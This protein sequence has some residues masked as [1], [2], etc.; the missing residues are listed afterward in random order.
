MSGPVD[1]DLL[2]Y[3]LCVKLGFCLPPE[4]TMKLVENPPEEV[5]AF[6]DAVIRAEGLDP[7]ILDSRVRRQVSEL[8][9]GHFRA[10]A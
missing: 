6:V 2:L 8:V 1:V 7:T 3:E 9:A 10:P 5:D 4:E